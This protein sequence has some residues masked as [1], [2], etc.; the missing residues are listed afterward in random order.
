MNIFIASISYNKKRL[1][2]KLFPELKWIEIVQEA[3][4]FFIPMGG[5]HYTTAM[6]KYGM[7]PIPK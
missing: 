6:Y 4:H 5:S 1:D 3:I 2:C 7:I